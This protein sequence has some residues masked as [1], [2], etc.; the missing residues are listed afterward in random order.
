MTTLAMSEENK[1]KL[2]ST[3]FSFFVG[4]HF[5][6]SN[7][8]VSWAIQKVWRIIYSILIDHMVS[9]VEEIYW[10]R[11]LWQN[12]AWGASYAAR[13]FC[14]ALQVELSDSTYIVRSF[15]A[16]W[17]KAEQQAA[18]QESARR[19]FHQL[20]FAWLACLP[21]LFKEQNDSFNPS[22]VCLFGF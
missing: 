4:H 21:L 19:C 15:V 20:G 7:L 14:L 18:L 11:C 16:C 2:Y 17:T 1:N 12:K 3:L 22:F 5:G 9:R 8:S 13:C 6:M 10:C